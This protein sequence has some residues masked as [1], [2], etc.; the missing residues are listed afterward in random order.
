MGPPLS[1]IQVKFLNKTQEL[2]EQL[3]RSAFSH[4]HIL[5][6]KNLS[7]YRLLL[8][9]TH[10]SLG[11]AIEALADLEEP[12]IF[13]EIQINPDK[14]VT[15]WGVMYAVT[16]MI[17]LFVTKTLERGNRSPKKLQAQ[18]LELVDPLL[19]LDKRW[20]V[21]QKAMSERMQQAV[22]AFKRDLS[23]EERRSLPI[24]L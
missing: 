24:L 6:E 3:A 13:G 4:G 1:H 19:R 18:A 9:R 20:G 8:E 17:A 16:G 12:R 22:V 14:T 23:D 2:V 5:S 10:C 15:S 7:R 11:A 21:V